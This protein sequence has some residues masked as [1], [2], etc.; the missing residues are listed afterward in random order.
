MKKHYSTAMDMA[1][2]ACAAMNNETFARIV[3]TRTVNVNGRTLTNDNKLL[4]YVDGCIGLKTGYTKAAGRTLVS[5]ARRNGQRLVAVTLQDGNDWADHAALYDYGFAAYPAQRAM[6]IG[7]TVGTLAVI[8]GLTTSVPLVAADSFSW[9]LAQGEKLDIRFDLPESLQAPVSAGTSAG[10]AVFSLA[11]KEVGRVELL[12]G[13]DVLLAIQTPPQSAAPSAVTAETAEHAWRDKSRAPR[14]RFVVSITKGGG[15]AWK[16]DYKSCWRPRAMFPPQQ[17]DWLAAGRVRVNGRTAQIGDRADP[18][19]DDVQVDGVPLSKKE[20]KT[21]IL[22]NKPRGICDRFFRRK[23]PSTVAELVRDAG[24]RVFPVG[25]LDMDS[26]GLLLLTNDGEL[27]QRLIHPSFQI[28]KTYQ[29]DVN[30]FQADSAVKLSSI[31]ELDGEAIHQ[32]TV[33][34]ISK[35]ADRARLSVVIHEG[36]NRQ[37]RR[38]CAACGLTVRRLRRVREHTLELGD[39]PVG[40]V[41][42]SDGGGTTAPLGE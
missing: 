33:E 25:R 2:L 31:T 26:E 39:L 30:G 34:V 42:A 35:A 29:V 15:A 10:Q 3:S 21:Y 11:G 20:N 36:K 19:R 22:L 5:C 32:A 18:D 37:I 17:R 9:P 38:M 8:G 13:S 41:A 27:M 4:S 6:T 23:G 14:A 16:N 1:V 28:D 7:E 12:C 40:E 24:T